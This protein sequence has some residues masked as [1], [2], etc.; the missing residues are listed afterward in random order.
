VIVDFTGKN[1][2]VYYEAGL[3]DAWK[4]DWIILTRSSADDVRH[5][6][7]IRYSNTMA[8]TRG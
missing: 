7:P 6:R 2:N 5:L 3:A 4:T 1:T 8:L